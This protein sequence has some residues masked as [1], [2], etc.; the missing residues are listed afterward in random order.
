MLIGVMADTHDHLDYL[1]KA[2]DAFAN[3]NVDLVIMAGDFVSPFVI[4]VLRGLPCR[5]IGC[6]G[7]NDANEIALAGGVRTFGSLGP[8]P[9]C[10]MTR[11]GTR[12][13]ISH[14]LEDIRNDPGQ[15]D[16]IVWAHTHKASLTKDRNGRLLVNP[17]E[18]C[19]WVFGKP[20]IAVVD[21]EAKSAELIDLRDLS[22]ISSA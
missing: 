14:K 9:L 18:A 4:P 5:L 20:T 17:G 13:L 11:D 7:D 15:Y 2:V 12:I 19:G 1:R 16:L 6:F 10:G 8:A 22:V 3:W 21:T